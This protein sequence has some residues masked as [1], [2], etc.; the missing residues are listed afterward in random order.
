L[1][2]DQPLNDKE[3][4]IIA[5]L[6]S[7]KKSTFRG[8]QETSK[9]SPRILKGYLSGNRRLMKQGFVTKEVN[10]NWKRGQPH[11]YSLTA[12][13]FA[14]ALKAKEEQ[15]NEY[16]NKAIEILEETTAGLD[17]EKVTR[18]W[19]DEDAA[20]WEKMV[21]TELEK[22][23]NKQKAQNIKALVNDWVFEKMR[24]DEHRLY[25]TFFRLHI[26]LSTYNNNNKKPAID[27]FITVISDTFA[28]PY[29]IPTR[30]LKGIDFAALAYIWVDDPYNHVLNE[31]T[32]TSDWPGCKRF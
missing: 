23:I 10:V 26:L 11:T 30:Y 8:I 21:N 9:I 7:K 32:W 20:E 19:A 14:A 2:N 1:T 15:A 4:Q 16:I 29:T 13:G 5:A 18:M 24:R 28:E 12:K 22:K 6:F 17:A 3:Q 27:E 25:D 31:I